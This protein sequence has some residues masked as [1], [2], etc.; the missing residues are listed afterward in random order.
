MATAPGALHIRDLL[1]SRPAME[2]GTLPPQL[3]LGVGMGTRTRH[4]ESLERTARLAVRATK[5]HLSCFLQPR[6]APCS[7]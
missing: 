3:A 4:A 1:L 6:R 7:V 2:D 5:G